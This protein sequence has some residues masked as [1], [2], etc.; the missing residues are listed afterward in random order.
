MDRVRTS[1]TGECDGSRRS[2]PGVFALPSRAAAMETIRAALERE[3][4]A[5]PILVTGVAGIGK[6]WLWKGLAARMS[7]EWRWAGMS[8]SSASDPVEFHRAVADALGLDRGDLDATMGSRRA[9]GDFLAESAADRLRWVLVID[10]AHNLTAKVGEEVRILA[11]RLGEPGGF[12]GMLVVGQTSLARRLMTRG[13][14]G[15]EGRLAARV[16]LR[17][18]DLEE[19]GELL[20]RLVPGYSWDRAT[21]ERHHRETGGIPGRLLRRA[22]GDAAFADRGPR[23]EI[24][25]PASKPLQEPAVISAPFPAPDPSQVAA[26]ARGEKG[27][28]SEMIGTSRPP[29]RV[30]E[31][32]IE[33]GWDPSSEP[34]ASQIE[35]AMPLAR[36]GK[37][38]TAGTG[39]EPI[40]DRYAAIQAWAEWT[41]NQERIP[42]SSPP[43]PA[44]PPI[45]L[46]PPVAEREIE[47]E[48]GPESDLDAAPRRPI[49]VNVR[50]EGQHEFS[51]YSNLFSRMRPSRE[52]P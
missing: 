5:G 42:E 1:A 24:P 4:A 21:L 50:A 15:L 48:S 18:L 35:K 28:G 33:V 22:S 26:G 29:L 17:P 51:P 41:R 47:P 30:E 9:V 46:R 13:L 38:S 8:L 37:P 52:A 45:D 6:T 39:E 23:D 34:D 19:S 12:S 32:L 14:A 16:H 44:R 31:G 40:D 36:N 7:A 25:A 43:A 11:D 10:E 20:G 2:D 49:M 27:W 3:P